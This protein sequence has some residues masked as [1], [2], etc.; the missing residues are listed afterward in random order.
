[1]RQCDGH[2]R[3]YEYGHGRG[4]EPATAVPD[5][6]TVQE[7]LPAAAGVA[8]DG[9]RPDGRPAGTLADRIRVAAADRPDRPA[10]VAGD[11]TVSWAELD[12]LVDTAARGI[13]HA[14]GG[15]GAVRADDGGHPPRV[16]IALGNTVEF[17][18]CYFATLRAGLV[19]VPLNPEFTAPELRHVLADSGARLLIGTDRVPDTTSAIATR[20]P[21]D[22]SR[23][24]RR[25]TRVSRRRAGPT[26][27]R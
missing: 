11:R 4:D 13:G 24:V 5:S 16:A 12:A 21:I 8:G 10:L 19:A 25:L 15:T 17:A 6:A 18:V 2:G 23:R 27:A 14:V 22:S 9:G 20:V 7:A 3:G 1:M 26:A